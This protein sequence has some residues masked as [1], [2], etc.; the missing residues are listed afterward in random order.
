MLPRGHEEE[1]FRNLA[2]NF[3]MAPDDIDC[4]VSE[5]AFDASP[6]TTA[7]E[8]SDT[9]RCTGRRRTRPSGCVRHHAT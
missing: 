6:T 3:D 9:A 4:M 1:A 8:T 5:L 7:P 2:R